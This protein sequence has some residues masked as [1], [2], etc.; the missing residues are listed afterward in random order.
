MDTHYIYMIE[1]KLEHKHNTDESYFYIGK[2]KDYPNRL[3]THISRNNNTTKLINN[4]DKKKNGKINYVARVIAIRKIYEIVLS[5]KKL[6]EI[7][8]KDDKIDSITSIIENQFVCDRINGKEDDIDKNKKI[9][10]G[11]H[12]TSE[13]NRPFDPH[14]IKEFIKDDEYELECVFNERYL[15]KD[16]FYDKYNN[17][18]KQAYKNEIKEYIQKKVN[19]QSIKNK[20]QKHSIDDNKIEDVKEN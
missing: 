1:L 14:I 10:R 11:G 19:E 2:T 15:I 20:E 7:N 5:E 17:N 9:F 16:D 18:E 12:Y 8:N 13:W 3:L 6:E 4:R